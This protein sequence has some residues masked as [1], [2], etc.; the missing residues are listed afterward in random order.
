MG[1]HCIVKIVTAERMRELDRRAIEEG[2]MP[3][4]VLMENAGRAV[5]ESLSDRFG[6]LRKK[7]ITLF[8][9]TGNNGGDGFV[10]ARLLKLAGATVVVFLSGEPDR[11]TGDARV[12]YKAMCSIGIDCLKGRF[13]CRGG[14]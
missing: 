5:F 7:Q 3:G 10:G 2:G 6:P 9:G 13:T 14:V 4:V 11:I 8:C 12:H 1:Y